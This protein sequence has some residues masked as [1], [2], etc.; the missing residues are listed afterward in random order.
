MNQER[1]GASAS[2]F[3]Y[4][5]ALITLKRVLTKYIPY[6]IIKGKSI[7]SVVLSDH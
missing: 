3:F 6:D 5:M 4:D 2:S 1:G 7:E